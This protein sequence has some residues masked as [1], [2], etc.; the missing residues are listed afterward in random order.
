MRQRVKAVFLVGEQV[1]ASGVGEVQFGF[2][3]TSKPGI[4]VL[5]VGMHRQTLTSS[6]R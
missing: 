4:E 6:T 3:L 1:V 5:S 2:A